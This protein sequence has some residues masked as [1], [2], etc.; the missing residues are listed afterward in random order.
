M[1]CRWLFKK[2]DS[3]VTGKITVESLMNERVAVG[4]LM[5]MKVL[6]S[7]INF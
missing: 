1:Q 5:L 7:E 4:I 3:L 2:D 6:K